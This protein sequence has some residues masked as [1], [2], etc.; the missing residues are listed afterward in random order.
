MSPSLIVDTLFVGSERD[1]AEADGFDVVVNCTPHLP[2]NDVHRCLNVR[3]PVQDDPSDA[4]PLFQILRDT[5]VLRDIHEALLEGRRVLVHCQ[6]GAQRS[7][8]VVACYLIKFR[9]MDPDGAIAF[10]KSRRPIAFFFHVNLAQTLSLMH[11]DVL[12]ARARVGQV[13]HVLPSVCT[14]S[15]RSPT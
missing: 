14:R 3:I 9:A 11:A 10:V 7:P 4:Y 13:E 8:V 2:F 12:R 5:P 1:A 15:A 6:A